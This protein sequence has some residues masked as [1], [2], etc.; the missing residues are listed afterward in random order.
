MSNDYEK[1]LDFDS[2]TFEE[3]KKDMNFV[4]QRLI[5][6]MQEKGTTEGSMTLKINVTMVKE[7]IKTACATSTRILRVKQER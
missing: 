2:D 3:M 6:N 1:R 7:F 4:L 5:G